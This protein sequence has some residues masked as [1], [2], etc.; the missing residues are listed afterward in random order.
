MAVD[1]QW[2]I[3]SLGPV[4]V[5]ARLRVADSGA[6]QMLQA[7]GE[8][9]H[10]PDEDAARDALLDAE[11]RAFDGLDEEDAE[12]L[13]FSLEDIGPPE[14]ENDAELIARMTQKP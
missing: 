11:F 1:D 10:Y 3:A 9:L 7:S 12:G 13:G 4:L 14:A 5:W 2:W 8:T 6:V